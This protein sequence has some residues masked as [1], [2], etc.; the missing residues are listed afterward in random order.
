MHTTVNLNNSLNVTSNHLLANQLKEQ[1]ILTENKDCIIVHVESITVETSQSSKKT[2]LTKPKEMIQAI[3]QA[4]FKKQKA[5]LVTLILSAFLPLTLPLCLILV[6]GVGNV[7]GQATNPSAH[8]LASSNFSFTTQTA[9]N[10]AYPTSM[11]G[12]TTGTNNITSLTTS[13]PVADQALVASG[14]ATTS[15]LSNL[16]SN[17]FNFLST[18]TS[19]NRQVGAVCLAIN[20]N[21]R[22]SINVSWLVDDQTRLGRV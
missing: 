19:P 11:Q 8:N 14:A 20:T 4:I 18:S 12:W 9:T 15:G 2:L 5:S 6:L 7:W 21:G 10:N 16:G 1:D 13:A 3:S 17:G 22:T